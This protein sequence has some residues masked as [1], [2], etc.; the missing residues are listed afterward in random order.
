[1]GRQVD[2]DGDLK[3]SLEKEIKPQPERSGDGRRQMDA[4]ERSEM[5]EHL[6]SKTESNAHG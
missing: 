5:D 2:M 4:T 6:Y 3:F 1:M